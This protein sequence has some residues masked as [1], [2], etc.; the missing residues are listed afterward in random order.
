MCVCLRLSVVC[1]ATIFFILDAAITDTETR[2]YA[3][4]LICLP[5]KYLYVSGMLLFLCCGC[6]KRPIPP[7]HQ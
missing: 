4:N 2:F 5:H 7:S 1:A 6:E 3:Y